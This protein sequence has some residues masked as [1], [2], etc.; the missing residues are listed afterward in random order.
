MQR[1]TRG[2]HSEIPA[3]KVKQT[4]ANSGTFTC[5][6]YS[7]LVRRGRRSHGPLHGD[8]QQGRLHHTTLSEQGNSESHLGS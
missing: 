6:E 3:A 8:H 2:D 5:S 1:M 7:L 4:I